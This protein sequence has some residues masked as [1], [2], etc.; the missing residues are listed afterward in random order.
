MPSLAPS[1]SLPHAAEPCPSCRPVRLPDGTRSGCWRCGDMLL[2]RL[3]SHRGHLL[4]KPPAIAFH[5]DFW[6]SQR[7]S[8]RCV[9]VV[10]TDTGHAWTA[11]IEHFDRHAITLSRGCGPQVAL[12]FRFWQRLD[13]GNGQRPATQLALAL[14]TAS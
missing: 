9:I 10:D 8:L 1:A 13:K 3:S 4:Q 5:E 2:R 12:P 11:P 6:Q 7:P 14:E